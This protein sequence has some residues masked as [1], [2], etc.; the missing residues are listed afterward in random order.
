M[1][2]L[3]IAVGTRGDIEPFLAIAELLDKKGHHI[4]CC[5]PEQLRKITADS[6]FPFVGLTPKYLEM[7][8]SKEGLIAMGG[9]AN[10]FQKIRA[11]YMLYNK[12]GIVNKIMSIEQNK[13]ISSEQPD[14]IIY[15]IKAN[16]PLIYETIN[17][18]KTILISPIPYMVHTVKEHAHIGFKNMGGFINKLTY[19]LAKLGLLKN[20]INATD[21]LYN[22]KEISS[23]Q[24]SLALVKGKTIYT[25]SPFLFNE[26]EYWA[27]NIKVLGYHERDKTSNWKLDDSL[28]K[29]IKTHDTI[30]FITFG[31]MVNAEPVKKTKLI[32]NVIEKLNIPAIINI[33]GGGLLKPNNF[34]SKLIH[35]VSSIPYDWLLPQIDY[36]VHHGGSGTTHMAIKYNCPSLI[37]PHI[38]DQFLWNDINY[39]K[40][41]GPKGIPINQITE[42]NLKPLI[43]ELIENEVYKENSFKAMKEMKKEN[44]KSELYNF[45]VD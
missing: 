43:A 15:H 28:Q 41:L 27:K 26:P 9:K 4:I 11:Y 32:T 16:Y 44:L 1:K 35:F 36:M 14:K 29:F 42:E 2:I 8:E 25:I 37:I 10:L 33:G 19:K 17:P 5:F 20:V 7:L 45:I 23:K 38:I 30:L 18:N 39:K 12:A 6:G 34:D 24:I 3:L 22:K 40:G 31:S 13:L 21:G